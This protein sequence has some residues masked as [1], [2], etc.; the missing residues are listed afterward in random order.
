MKNRSEIKKHVFS[1]LNQDSLYETL[2]GIGL[3]SPKEC[4]NPLFS[5]I[6]RPEESV[7]WFAISCFGVVLGE[8]VKEDKEAARVVMRRFLW[9]L[10]DESGGIGWG[11]P[12]SMAESM[13]CSSLLREEY[14]H[15][16]VSYAKH[17]GED[18]FQDGNYLELQELQ[19]GLLWGLERVSSHFPKE[20]DKY[21][22]C[23]ELGEYLTASDG[24][25]RG[26]ALKCVINLGLTN[27]FRKQIT[28][29]MNDTNR[30]R[31]YK[32]GAF[33]EYKISEIASSIL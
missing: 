8:L 23:L 16:L 1:L 33:V 12:E 32:N 26:M 2:H 10:N 24:T 5:A 29:L 9:S 19:R 3:M 7:R 31:F 28:P 6:C 18:L 20:F 14:L 21:D 17:D 4:I 30:L 13:I 22:I 25:V 15:M 27:E 11:A